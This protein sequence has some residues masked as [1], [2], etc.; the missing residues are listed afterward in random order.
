MESREYLVASQG[1]H[2]TFITN[3]AHVLLV[4]AGNPD[5]RLRDVGDLVG[6]T[7]RGTQRIVRDLVKD[8]YLRAERVGRRNHYTIQTK[9]PLRHPIEANHTVGELIDVFLK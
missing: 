7:E 1:E 4:L 2:W 3:H 8:G 6:I 5:M 9:M